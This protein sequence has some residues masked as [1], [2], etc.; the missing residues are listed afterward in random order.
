LQEEKRD[1]VW[2]DIYKIESWCRIVQNQRPWPYADQYHSE[3]LWRSL[4]AD[5]SYGSSPAHPDLRSSFRDFVARIFAINI[6][7]AHRFRLTSEAFW[8]NHPA[9]RHLSDVKQFLPSLDEIE[10][11]KRDFERLLTLISD[12]EK[13]ALLSGQTQVPTDMLSNNST[14]LRCDYHTQFNIAGGQLFS[15]TYGHVGLAPGLAKLDDVLCF[16]Q[17]ARVPFV[18]RPG[19]NQRYRLVGDCYIHGLMRGEVESLGLAVEDILLE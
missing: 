10:A 16:I 6:I 8:D 18:L 13:E 4:I 11:S 1:E 2:T 12:A 17:G 19:L 5:Q 15:S 14:L 3:V 9:Y 7:H